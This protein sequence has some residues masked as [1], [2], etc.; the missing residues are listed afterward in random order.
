MKKLVAFVCFLVMPFMGFSTY[1][2][3]CQQD[4]IIHEKFFW[5]S[6]AG[7]FVD[8]GAHNGITF[9]NTCF[10][11]KELGWT[12]ICIEPIPE[13]FE[14]LIVNRKC[15]CIQGCITDYSGEGKFF[16]VKSPI[17][18]VEM[19][20]GLAKKYN[21]THFNRMHFELSQSGGSVETINVKCYVLHEVLEQKGIT[22][23][24]LLSIDTEG[25]EFEILSS[26]DFSKFQVDVITVEDN[27]NDPRFIPFLQEKGFNFVGHVEQ[28]LLFMH[29]NFVPKEK[30]INASFSGSFE[31][32]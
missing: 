13:V 29:K 1:H 16:R 22:H 10:F 8:I 5:N 24:N 4:Q 11:E 18:H 12:G 28:D 32:K 17:T 15:H 7:T 2:S 25:G 20:S 30:P 3:Q 14:Q 31:N 9:S 19:L 21:P 23:V 6:P 26:I 27:Y